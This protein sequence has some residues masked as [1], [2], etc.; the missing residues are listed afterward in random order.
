MAMMAIFIFEA[1][2]GGYHVYKNAYVGE[3]FPAERESG[4]ANDRYPGMLFV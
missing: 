1:A 3:E 2:V 4:N